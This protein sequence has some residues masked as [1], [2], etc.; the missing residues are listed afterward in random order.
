MRCSPPSSVY[1]TSSDASDDHSMDCRTTIQGP[2]PK[3]LGFRAT[4]TIINLG[5]IQTGI[6]GLAARVDITGRNDNLLSMATGLWRRG[7]ATTKFAQIC[8]LGQTQA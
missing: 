3:G 8:S 4:G 5:R 6:A 1:M 7:R 2:Y